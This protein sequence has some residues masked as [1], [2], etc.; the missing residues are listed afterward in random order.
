MKNVRLYHS[1]CMNLQLHIRFIAYICGLNKETN[2][3][4]N[5]MRKK[6]TYRYWLSALMVLHIVFISCKDHEDDKVKPS[7]VVLKAGIY[8]FESTESTVWKAGEKFGVFMVKAGTEEVTDSY[9]NCLYTADDYSAT[10]YLIPAKEP[11]YYPSDGSKVD[12][13][14][15]YPYSQNLSKTRSGVEEY[16]VPLN[17]S[18]QKQTKADALIYSRE[19]E[20]L[21]MGSRSHELQLKPVLSRITL[22]LVPS[23]GIAAD[24]LKEMKV[25]LRGVCTDG[26]FDLLK[27]KFTY[28]T[29]E[30]EVEMKRSS[31]TWQR[32]AVLFPGEID[33]K[34]TIAVALETKGGDTRWL[35][36]PLREAIVHLKENMQY[37]LMLKVKPDKLEISLIK[38]S[39]IYIID[40]QDDNDN[41]SDNI[42]MGVPNLV[43]EG[44]LET[45]DAGQLASTV[46]VPKSEYVWYGMANSVKGTFDLL[47][48]Q[49]RGNV[50]CMSF[51]DKP[52]WYKS[53][54]AYTSKGA[55]AAHYQLTFKARSNMPGA[56]LQTYVRINKEGNH[57]FVLKDADT[58]KACAARMHEL[59]SE[60]VTYV[61][62]WDFAQTVNTIYA[63]NIAITPSST[64]DRNNFYLA[65]ASQTE[66]AEYYIDDITFMKQ[67]K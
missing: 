62:D 41:V 21:S 51:A 9:A 3:I 65:F 40:W 31:E 33:K 42:D 37:E 59:T 15:Y 52:V 63:T 55:E 27:G 14:A 26:M 13:R 10:G 56:R 64:N 47:N 19:G 49:G 16:V 54:L 5:A 45:L 60:W 17:L 58:S 36:I 22:E 29:A 46:S 48:E 25:C 61:V 32:E 7:P 6:N 38:T 67:R 39:S 12:I 24:H 35:E 28:L 43:K 44:T 34:L 57:F 1:I 2:L 23:A 18:D 11:M 20:G 53:Y 50:W 4:I 30:K 66:G 8:E